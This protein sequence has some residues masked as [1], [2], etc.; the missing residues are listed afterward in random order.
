[1][2]VKYSNVNYTCFKLKHIN[3]ALNVYV[4]ERLRRKCFQVSTVHQRLKQN[5]YLTI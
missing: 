1:M 2:F 4:Q 5:M 3:V